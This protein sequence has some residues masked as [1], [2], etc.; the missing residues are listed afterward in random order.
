MATS[1]KDK[2]ETSTFYHPMQYL[3]FY[4]D[5]RQGTGKNNLINSVH[6][7]HMTYVLYCIL[8]S[9]YAINQ[10]KER[11]IKIEGHRKDEELIFKSS[12]RRQ[13]NL[14]GNVGRFLSGGGEWEHEKTSAN[15]NNGKKPPK[16]CIHMDGPGKVA[17]T[18][19]KEQCLGK[20]MSQGF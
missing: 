6:F 11:E 4:Q 15:Q 12:H 10:Q 17:G 3:H 16:T 13:T 19:L 20:K 9:I 18:S 14:Q 1:C 8:A 2:T 5:I 7:F